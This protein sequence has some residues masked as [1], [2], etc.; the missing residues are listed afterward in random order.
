MGTKKIAY[1]DLTLTRHIGFREVAKHV[2]YVAFPQQT[3]HCLLQLCCH[4]WHSSGFSC[5][6]QK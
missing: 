5:G 6:V 3:Y 2:T 1:K 4:Y